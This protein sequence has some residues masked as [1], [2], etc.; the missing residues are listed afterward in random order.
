MFSVAV[1]EE[2]ARLADNPGGREH[3]SLYIYNHPERFRLFNVSSGLPAEAATL[4]LTVDTP[5]DFRLI[6]HIHEH[7]YASKPDFRLPY[8]LAIFER[9]P[10]LLAV[11]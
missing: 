2:A 7:L 9:H 6:I 4:R 10:A 11:N 1:L 3:V 5:G 8:I